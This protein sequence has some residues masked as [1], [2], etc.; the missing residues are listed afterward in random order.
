MFRSLMFDFACD[1]QV[2]NMAGEF[3]YG[4]AYLV[5]PVTKAMEYGP[6]NE[7]LKGPKSWEVYLPVG[8]QWYHQKTKEFY[9][10][11]RAYEVE[12]PVTWQP[13]FYPGRFHNSRGQQMR[14][15]RHCRYH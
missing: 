15:K 2:K 3:M 12:A 7:K 4:P 8:A 11:G 1:P 14:Q 6:E 9:A 10:G 5:C 13:V